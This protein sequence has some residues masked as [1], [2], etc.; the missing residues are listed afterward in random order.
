MSTPGGALL[1]AVDRAAFAVA[2]GDRLRRHGVPVGLPLVQDFVTAL[3]RTAPRSRTG[4]YWTARICL[5]RDH[6]DLSEFDAVFDAV[7]GDAVLPADPHARR[8]GPGGTPP[9][10]DRHAPVPGNP[11]G[12]SDGGGLPWVARPTTVGAA[13]STAEH[14]LTM[15]ERLPSDA[16]GLADTPFERLGPRETRLLGQWLETALRHW[17]T[18]RS[19][20]FAAG[21]R[22]ARIAVRATVT[23]S[24]RTGWE[25]VLL[26]RDGPVARPR[27]VVMLCDV[28]R[29]MQPQ[30]VAYL[31]LMRALALTTDAEAFAFATSLTRLTGVLT[32]RSAE[33]AI[34]EASR[35]V[36]DRFGG[37]RIAESLRTLL[38]SHHGGLLRGAVVIIGSDGWDGDPPERL[39]AAMARLH[40]RAHRVIWLNPRCAAPGFAPRTSTM[41]AALPYCDAL[42][43]GDTFASLLRLTTEITRGARRERRGGTA[44]T[45]GRAAPVSSRESHGRRA[46]TARP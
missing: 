31:H 43:P 26:V 11:H 18:R 34:D 46:G 21:P 44:R 9:E 40:R 24:R 25:P 16:A 27:R 1:P 41:A 3:A 28:S 8:D 17:P 13:D 14:A 20:R 39:A 19:R 6:D 5:V 29:S 38:D 35:R 10:D 30:A 7:F 42:L 32:H 22:G 36:V 33:A 4:L 45:V 2:L 12:R 15:P 23:R 37:T